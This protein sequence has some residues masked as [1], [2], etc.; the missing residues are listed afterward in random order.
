MAEHGSHSRGK[1]RG[2]VTKRGSDDAPVDH[3]QKVPG[4]VIADNGNKGYILYFYGPKR[5][6]FNL[7]V[8]KACE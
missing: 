7:G 6:I 5:G 8:P 1:L 3:T 2:S 4:L